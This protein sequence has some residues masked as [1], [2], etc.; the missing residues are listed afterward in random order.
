MML[1]AACILPGASRAGDAVSADEAYLDS[2][3]GAWVMVGNVGD[4]AVRYEAEGERVLRGGFLK[5][6]MKDASQPSTYEAAVFI[7]YDA[8]ARDYVVHWLDQFGAAGARVVATGTRDGERLV[9]TFPYAEGPFRDTLT[10]DATKG[11]WTLLLESQKK[12]GAWTTFARYDMT[13]PVDS[14]R[15]GSDSPPAQRH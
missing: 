4:K 8:R 9:V 7:G 1:L 13:R 5:L 2:L 10:R 6:H 14:T 11:T 3:M 15:G 12:D